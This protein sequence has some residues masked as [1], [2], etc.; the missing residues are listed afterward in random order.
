MAMN[1]EQKRALQRAGQLTADGSPVAT[2][3]RRQPQVRSADSRTSP[4]DFVR[5][6][7][8]ELRKVSWPTRAETIRLSVIV[9]IAIVI[10]G[11]FIFLID[12][13]FG[14][15]TDFLFPSPS[16]SGS[17]LSGAWSALF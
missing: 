4:A 10:L 3:E 13:G 15:F 8:A 9:F 14:Q 6:V 12:L 16:T 1:R 7:R 17:L 11:A 2:R 5:E